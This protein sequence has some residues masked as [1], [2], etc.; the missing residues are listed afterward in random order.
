MNADLS[1]KEPPSNHSHERFAASG[2]QNEDQTVSGP[3]SSQYMLP[4]SLQDV[5]SA[6]QRQMEIMS[7]MSQRIM[8]LEARQRG[9]DDTESQSTQPPPEYEDRAFK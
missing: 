9:N 8:V 5:K 6:I 3:A 1:M 2:S 4:Q 7:M